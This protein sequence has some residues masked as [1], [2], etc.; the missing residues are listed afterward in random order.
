MLNVTDVLTDSPGVSIP[1]NTVTVDGLIFID[2]LQKNLYS[3]DSFSYGCNFSDNCNDE[4][5]L[6]KILDSLLIEDQLLQEIGP[7][8]QVVSPFDAKAAGCLNFTNATYDCPETDLNNCFNCRIGAERSSNFNE[9]IC[10]SC[11]N[12]ATLTNSVFRHKD[13]YLNNRTESLDTAYLAC[14]LN[15]CNSIE[16]INH[17]Y[18]ASNITFNFDKFFK[19]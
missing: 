6:T 10:A 14:Q 4:K 2:I 11:P 17:I 19:N 18:K 9:G 16:N 7:L 3:F 8:L 12:D 13:F 1:L 15:G 5:A